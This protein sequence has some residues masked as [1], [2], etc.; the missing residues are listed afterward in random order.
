MILVTG[1]TGTV[2][3]HLLHHLLLKN[4]KI[5][6]IIRSDKNL[7]YVKKVFSYFT[8]DIDSLF[9]RIEWLKADLTEISKI[10]S[11]IQK[12][13]ITELYHCAAM[14]SFDNKDQEKLFQVNHIGTKQLLKVAQQTNVNK[15]CLI[16]SIACLGMDESSKENPVTENDVI[17]D[18]SLPISN[19]SRTKILAEQEAFKVNGNGLNVVL[20]NPSVILAPGNWDTSSG[21]IFKEASKGIPFYTDGG[22]GFV[23]VLDVVKIAVLLMEEELYGQRFILNASNCRYKCI[24]DHVA[25]VIGVRKPFLKLS[26]LLLTIVSKLE[27]LFCLV[28]KKEQKLTREIVNSLSGMTYYSNKKIVEQL[29]YHFIDIEKTIHTYSKLFIKENR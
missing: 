15:F 5:F 16:S 4:K 6:A 1:G 10:E 11:Y 23:D 24:F 9:S 3:A 25:S 13:E 12:Y 26:K 8:E 19:Y 21:K 2:G 18:L 22:T 7:N 28:A 14:V 29:D 20:V 27:A 17:T